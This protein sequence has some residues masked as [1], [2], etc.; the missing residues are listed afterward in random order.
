METIAEALRLLKRQASIQNDVRRARGSRVVEERE[1]FLIRNRLG[2]SPLRCRQSRSPPPSYT[3]PWI[4][5][6]SATSR[7][8]ASRAC[9]RDGPVTRDTAPDA[10]YRAHHVGPA[11]APARAFPSH[12]R[13]SPSRPPYSRPNNL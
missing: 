11:R 12:H 8:A 6:R 5:F 13:R 10:L 1:L 4:P 9:R 3:G 7:S 2:S